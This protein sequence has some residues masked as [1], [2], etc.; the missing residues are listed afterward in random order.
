MPVTKLVNRFLS[1]CRQEKNLLNFS[2]IVQDFYYAS[3]PDSYDALSKLKELFPPDTEKGKNIP[4]NDQNIH[5]F[6]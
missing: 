5:I 3:E 2:E 1:A 6:F 4:Y